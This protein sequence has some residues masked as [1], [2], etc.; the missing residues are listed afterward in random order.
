MLGPHIAA[1][2]PDS[3]L[4]QRARALPSARR[5][6]SATASRKSSTDSAGRLG[7]VL[8]HRACRPAE[9]IDDAVGV[10][11]D[12]GVED[13]LGVI[14]LRDCGAGRIRR[15]RRSPRARN[16]RGSSPGRSGAAPRPPR[17]CRRPDWRHGRP[18]P[19]SR[20]ASATGRRCA[21]RRPGPCA[22]ME[23]LAAANRCRDN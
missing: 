21:G 1:G 16:R 13:E 10:A 23:A 7:L 19:S 22:E 8:R 15:R 20:P 3:A 4:H 12:R 14:V 17:G 9:A 11:A 2:S 18:P 5:C 6:G